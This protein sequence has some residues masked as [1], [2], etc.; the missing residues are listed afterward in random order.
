RFDNPKK[1]FALIHPA[2]A[3]D[4]KRW[5]AENFAILAEHLHQIGLE[6]IAVAAAGEREILNRLAHA[7]HSPLILTDALTLPEISAL[8]SRAAIFVGN[9][10]GI[11]HMAAAVGTPCV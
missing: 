1:N 10:S 9:D 11:A 4:T 2:A 3:F 8:A 6:T 5:P 7:A